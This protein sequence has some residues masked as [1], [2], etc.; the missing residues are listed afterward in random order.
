M[1]AHSL[2]PPQILIVEDDAKVADVVALYLQREGFQVQTVGDG[3]AALRAV[4]E[5]V[6][7][8]VVLDIMLPGVD[9]LEVCRTLRRNLPIPIIMLTALGEESDQVLGLDLGADDYI[10][11]PFSPRELTARVKAVLRR[12]ASPGPGVEPGLTEPLRAGDIIIDLAA[13]EVRL[14]DVPVSLTAREYELLA[15][16]VTHPVKAFTREELLERV[17]GYVYGDTSTVTVHVR[18]LR[19]KLEDESGT[20][21]HIQTVWGVGYRFQP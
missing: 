8:L 12:V 11:K 1:L 3:S 4:D 17:W 21:R 5:R 10:T 16:L 7:D 2:A 20:P 18:R 15:F 13:R 14:R 6:P 9:G 19:G